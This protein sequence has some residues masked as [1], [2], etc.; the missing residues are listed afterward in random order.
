MDGNYAFI[1]GQNLYLSTTNRKDT[2]WE[3]DLYK[4]RIYLREKYNVI[5]AFYFMGCLM[6]DK[7]GLYEEIQNAGYILVFR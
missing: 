3:V 6:G 5:K 7:N 1:D 2:S 4:F